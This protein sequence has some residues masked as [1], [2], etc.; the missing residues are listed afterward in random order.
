MCN[1]T[2]TLQIHASN[3][4]SLAS[5]GQMCTY[6]E[7]YKRSKI[8][9]SNLRLDIFQFWQGIFN[10]SIGLGAAFKPHKA[11]SQETFEVVPSFNRVGYLARADHAELSRHFVPREFCRF[12]PHISSK[13]YDAVKK[14]CYFERLIRRM[15]M[16]YDVID[17]G[18][19]FIRPCWTAT[20]AFCAS[21][22][23]VC[24]PT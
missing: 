12:G 10:F 18:M 21:A 7:T 8:V 19:C 13:I 24:V 1:C 23:W 2:K 11:T 9:R 17:F 14:G 20:L 15:D 6:F 22:A 3:N 5:N 4:A 16:F